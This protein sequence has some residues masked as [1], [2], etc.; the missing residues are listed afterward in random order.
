MYIMMIGGIVK[1]R[2]DC[3]QKIFSISIKNISEGPIHSLNYY[4]KVLRLPVKAK[5]KLI[6]EER[7]V[8][9]MRY[10]K[11]FKYL[12]ALLEV[13]LYFHEDSEPI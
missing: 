6:L 1:T 2:S 11:T 13:N 12:P 8:Y 5:Q 9:F 4:L 3:L 10:S 7:S